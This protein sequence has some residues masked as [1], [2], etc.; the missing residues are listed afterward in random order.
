MSKIIWIE[1][2]LFIDFCYCLFIAIFKRNVFFRYNEKEKNCLEKKLFQ[3]RVIEKVFFLKR[4][5]KAGLNMNAKDDEGCT[6]EY[7][8]LKVL[9]ECIVE[10]IDNTNACGNK[11]HLDMLKAYIGELV[12]MKVRFLV[13]VAYK[14][15]KENDCKHKIYI[16]RSVGTKHIIKYFNRIGISITHLYCEVNLFKSAARPLY[17]LIKMLGSKLFRKKIATNIENRI[18]SIWVGY[19]KGELERTNSLSFWRN[20]LNDK[21]K[22]QIVYYLFDPQIEFEN[23]IRTIKELNNYRWIDIRKLY[24]TNTLTNIDII[25]ELLSVLMFLFNKNKLAYIAKRHY[26]IYYKVYLELF[27]RFNVKII[28]QT[29]VNNWQQTAQAK[30]IEKNGGIMI[31]FNWSNRLYLRQP[32]HICPHHVYFVWGSTTYEWL[33]KKGNTCKY[34]LPCGLY[35]QKDKQIPAELNNFFNTK[36]GF[37]IAVFDSSVGYQLY[38]CKETL[39]QFYV[40]IIELFH[41]NKQWRG[42]L[43]SKNW[44]HNELVFLPNGD[45]IVQKLDLLIKSGRLLCLDKWIS[46]ATL[47]EFSD[48]AVCYAINSAGMIYSI[49]GKPSLHWDCS[50]WLKHPIYSDKDQRLVFKEMDDVIQAVIDFYE[51]K[52]VFQG[53][54]TWANGYNYFNDLNAPKRVADFIDAFMSFTKDQD[55]DKALNSAVQKYINDNGVDI[56]RL[57]EQKIWPKE[58]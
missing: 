23:A 50:G 49:H 38:Q 11:W 42:I 2:L 29:N 57:E 25:N 10:I 13:M 52:W 14:I 41:K 9:D 33:K 28:L 40:K 30:A 27:K 36:A 45:E 7:T 5:Q 16:R 43:K 48:I 8:A 37:T 15:N 12:N 53:L 20:E 4:F 6:L 51:G 58:D 18:P 22:R 35:I 26:E 24:H 54:G 21:K 17:F 31:G 46:P 34:I 19:T 55:Y 44:N 1:K 32:T 39:S 47:S 56:R 3:N